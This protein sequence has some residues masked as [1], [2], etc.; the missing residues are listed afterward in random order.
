MRIKQWALALVLGLPVLTSATA[1]VQSLPD[2]VEGRAAEYYR[3]LGSADFERVW[4]FF[5]PRM[6]AD[7]SRDRYVQGVKGAF[8]EVH[9]TVAPRVISTDRTG[10]AGRPTAKLGTE[11]EFTIDGRKVKATHTTEWVWQRGSDTTRDNWYL[12]R[13]RLK[14]QPAPGK[15][16]VTS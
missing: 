5:G 14:E 4:S 10:E 6:K 1:Q 3:A 13:E 7:T 11:L 2:G 12:V 9:V 8:S 16:G 15:P